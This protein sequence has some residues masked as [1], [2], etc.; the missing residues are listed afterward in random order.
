M[1]YRIYLVPNWI[2]QVV[3]VGYSPFTP[4]GYPLLK[5]LSWGKAK[6]KFA[7]Q[8]SYWSQW[9]VYR[10]GG[11]CLLL[12]NESDQVIEVKELE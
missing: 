12:T 7:R 4:L 10:G 5:G 11:W 9:K 3:R 2:A 1:K 6:A 8:H